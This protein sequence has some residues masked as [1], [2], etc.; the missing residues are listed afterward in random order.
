M[1]V[2]IIKQEDNIM[3]IQVL[4]KI[5]KT[6]PGQTTLRKLGIEIPDNN[7]TLGKRQPAVGCVSE[8]TNTHTHSAFHI[9]TAY[10]RLRGTPN[11]LAKIDREQHNQNCPLGLANIIQTQRAKAR[12]KRRQQL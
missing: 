9:L 4:Q 7:N 8:R 11:R 2:S 5:R 6:P 1:L 10:N 3:Y 12:V